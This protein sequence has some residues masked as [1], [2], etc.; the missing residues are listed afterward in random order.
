MHFC[1]QFRDGAAAEVLGNLDEACEAR[2]LNGLALSEKVEAAYGMALLP[3]GELL[4]FADHELVVN[5]RRGAGD[6][7]VGFRQERS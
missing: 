4:R 1:R 7:T 6:C 3:Y 5:F 2:L